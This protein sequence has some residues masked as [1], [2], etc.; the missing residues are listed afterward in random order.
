MPGADSK[1][2]STWD[3]TISGAYKQSVQLLILLWKESVESGSNEMPMQKMS[4]S[5]DRQ[6]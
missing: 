6:T 4:V 2:V 1:T 5:R 3:G